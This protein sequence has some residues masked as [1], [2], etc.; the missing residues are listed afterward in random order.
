M[1]F[2]TDAI[3]AILLVIITTQAQQPAQPRQADDVPVI[4]GGVGPCALDLTVTDAEG[5]PVY[6]ANVKVHITYG[7][8]GI[9]KLDLEAGTNAQGRVKFQGLPSKVHNPPL[10]FN[11]TKDKLTGIATYDPAAECQAKHDIIV[12]QPKDKATN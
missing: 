2:F 1:K 8:A 10:E 11:A 12:K 9:R 6:A 3:A 7:F 5:K 4:D